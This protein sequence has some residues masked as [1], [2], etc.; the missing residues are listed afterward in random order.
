[1]GSEKWALKLHCED[2]G[3][4][5]QETN[6]LCGKEV[7]QP[8]VDITQGNL[9]LLWSSRTLSLWLKRNYS[10]K[11]RNPNLGRCQKTCSC[12][13]DI[14]LRLAGLVSP[15]NSLTH[16]QLSSLQITPV[17]SLQ[18]GSNFEGQGQTVY[19]AWGILVSEEQK[20][21]IQSRSLGIS[22]PKTRSKG[23]NWG[24]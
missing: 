7:S 23:Q 11:L 2:S 8:L 18:Q 22:E 14:F 6:S 19:P 10:G 21:W 16:L 3:T 15:K 4:I 5:G 12:F 13:E 9:K 1:M 20:G 17:R 24:P